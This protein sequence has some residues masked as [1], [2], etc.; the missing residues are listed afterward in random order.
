MD[1]NGTKCISLVLVEAGTNKEE[2]GGFVFKK[3]W[4]S[5]MRPLSRLHL[6]FTCGQPPGSRDSSA[7]CR[8]AGSCFD[9]PVDRLKRESLNIRATKGGY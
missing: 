1:E 8:E 9:A 2:F 5:T 4:R 7:M 6:F 3:R